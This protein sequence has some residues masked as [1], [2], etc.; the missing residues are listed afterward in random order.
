MME[1][2]AVIKAETASSASEY[3]LLKDMNEMAEK[4]YAGMT[5]QVA[6]LQPQLTVRARHLHRPNRSYVVPAMLCKGPPLSCWSA[7]V[8]YQFQQQ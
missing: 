2:A 4:K 8:P 6:S 3:T 7:D 5:Q 1:L